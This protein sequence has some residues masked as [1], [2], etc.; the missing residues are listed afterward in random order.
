MNNEANPIDPILSEDQLKHVTGYSQPTKQRRA[1]DMM[2]IRYLTR[3]DGKN[4]VPQSAIN[5]ESGAVRASNPQP[6]LA[7]LDK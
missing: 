1:L 5:G 3:P 4:I 6:N 2:G 7:A